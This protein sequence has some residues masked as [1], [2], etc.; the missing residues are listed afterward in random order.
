MAFLVQESCF[1][2][3]AALRETMR[4][5]G[6][7]A[8]L[9]LDPRNLMYL[10]NFHSRAI[11]PAAAVVQTDGVSALSKRVEDNTEAFADRT[12]GYESA[13]LGTLKEDVVDLALGPLLPLLGKAGRIGVDG[14]VLPWLLPGVELVDLRPAIAALQRRKW[15][16]EVAIIESA[17]G[18]SEAAYRAVEGLF[19]PGVPEIE[20]FAAF[21]AAAVVAAGEAIG[22]LGNDYRGG[23]GGGTPRREPLRG[24]DLVPVDTGVVLRHYYSDLCRTYAVGGHWDEGQMA[25]ARRV[26]EALEL[27]ESLI[28]PGVSCKSV[29]EEVH[30]FLDGYRGWRF[31]HHLGHGIGLHPIEAPR[32]NPHW[33]DVFEVG[34]V[35]T[36]EPGLYVGELRG[37]VRLENDYV[38]TATGLR[39]LSDSTGH[40][41]FLATR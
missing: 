24:G 28:A 1:A 21:Q 4:R 39:R 34:D 20:L 12:L 38:L 22:E 19:V 6:V 26:A 16:D 18:A 3:Q 13:R 32:I 25:A 14:P 17:I 11:Y 36:L 41:G 31:P 2:R 8:V 33:G 27:A 23:A 35:F 10:F 9:V 15:D 40:L 5:S 29:Y 7:D 37:G 30:A